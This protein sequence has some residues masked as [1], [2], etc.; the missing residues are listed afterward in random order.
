MNEILPPAQI[1]MLKVW[2]GEIDAGVDDAHI[3]SRPVGTQAT[4]AAQCL[5]FVMSLAKFR[6]LRH[7][8][9]FGEQS[10]RPH[11]EQNRDS[12]QCE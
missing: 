9:A 6:V 2:M 10:N 3:D 5:E 12:K 4:K 7:Q 8:E 11:R 1:Q